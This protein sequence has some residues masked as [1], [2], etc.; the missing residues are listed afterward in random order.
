MKL[1]L[2]HRVQR[3]P[4]FSK[5]ER[6]KWFLP[7]QIGLW[8]TGVALLV[9]CISGYTV[10]ARH[11]AQ[12]KATFAELTSTRDSRTGIHNPNVTEADYAEKV[13]TGGLIGV[14]EIPRLKISSVVDEGVD[15]KTL[16]VAVGHVPGT[17]FPGG[18]GN[19]ALAAH[20]DTFFRELG[21]LHPGDEITMTTLRGAYR[22][23][24][25]STRVVKPSATEVLDSS[26]GSKLT[27]I[28][29]Y[30]FHFVGPAPRR[31]VVVARETLSIGH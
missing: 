30:P 17:A 11:Q 2:F 8:A 14:I 5:S 15:N 6:S 3:T 1:A 26:G 7:L 24:V 9:Y 28:T 13:V 10:S 23:S 27:L 18:G 29:C 31:F 22:Y 16:L 4:R 21:Q 19:V 25:E 20:R 12:Q